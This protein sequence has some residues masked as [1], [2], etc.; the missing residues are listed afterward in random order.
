MNERRVN[1]HIISDLKIVLRNV[2]TQKKVV[3]WGEDYLHSVKII[4]YFLVV[5]SHLCS[6][7]I[8]QSCKGRCDSLSDFWLVRVV[9]VSSHLPIL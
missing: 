2:S 8:S 7:R 5:N 1:E 9:I 3:E 6:N 4:Q